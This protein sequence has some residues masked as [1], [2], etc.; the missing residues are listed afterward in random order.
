MIRRPPRSTLFPYTTLFRSEDD[1]GDIHPDPAPRSG[2]DL[3]VEIRDPAG[4]SVP[5]TGRRFRTPGERAGAQRVARLKHFVDVAVEHLAR[6]VAEQP[7]SRPV[8]GADLAALSDGV[9]GVRGLLE[10]REQLR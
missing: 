6:R 4:R 3:Q 2:A 8:P 5:A 7:L 10:Q 1:C 9:R